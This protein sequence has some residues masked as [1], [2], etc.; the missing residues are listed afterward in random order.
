[1]KTKFFLLVALTVFVLAGPLRADK[2]KGT[3]KPKGTIAI[4]TGRSNAEIKTFCVDKKGR[5]LVAAGGTQFSYERAE[6]G[7]YEMKLLDMPS[8]IHVFDPE[9]RETA[10]WEIEVTPQALAVGPDNAVYAAG[11][12]RIVKL[13]ENGKVLQDLESPHMKELPPLPP[14]PEKDE[15]ETDAEKDVRKNRLK[16]I[17]D[18]MKP[19]MKRLMEN[20]KETARARRS[21]DEEKVTSLRADQERIVQEYVI[22][23]REQKNLQTSKRSAAVETRNAVLRARSVRSI[24]VT[25][26]F[27]FVCT[28]PPKGYGNEVWRMDADFENPKVVVKKL[29]GCCGQMNIGATGD[30]LVVPENGRMKVHVYDVE[31]KQ[32]ES[33]G[34]RDSDNADS[35]F[36]SCCNP[37]N[38]A[39]DAEGNILTSESS[40]GA[41]KRFKQNG[42]Y[43]GLVARSSIVPGCNHTPIGLSLD[44]KKAYMLDLT[45]KQIIVLE[46]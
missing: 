1:M 6:N 10:V 38:I 9:G 21:K 20:D 33:W 42:E 41:I 12:G 28:P 27:I 16:E 34:D 2:A 46:E 15:D 40:V 19:I 31:G 23:A 43:L 13:D 29:S 11:M 26:H 25:D 30:K 32:L 7:D 5:L 44:G 17:Q 4:S 22:L 45:R 8:A 36:G 39:F 24:A 18:E 14:I 37:M 35:G 3:H